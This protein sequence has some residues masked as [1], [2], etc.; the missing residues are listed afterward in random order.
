[1]NKLKKISLPLIA[2]EIITILVL[3]FGIKL[4]MFELVKS[5]FF[6]VVS[7]FFAGF[8][9]SKLLSCVNSS[10]TYAFSFGFGIG[11]NILSYYVGKT[12]KIDYLI[13]II[14]AVI[15]L[16]GA[17]LFYKDIKAKK[18]AQFNVSHGEIIFL[19]AILILSVIGLSYCNLNPT[20]LGYTFNYKDMIW[21]V[22]NINSLIL[23]NPPTD[24]RFDGLPFNYHYFASVFRAAMSIAT[25]ISAEK[26]MFFY[27]QFASV[28]F[29]FFALVAIGKRFLKSSTKALF[30]AFVF[31][32]TNSAMTE[33]IGRGVGYYNGLQGHILYLH[34]GL[35]FAV[36]FLIITILV[37]LKTINS[38][39]TNYAG[40]VILAGLSAIATGS[41]GPMGTI[42][43]AMA[44]GMVFIAIIKKHNIK[45]V[46]LAS[47]A[48]VI[49]FCLVFFTVLSSAT[50]DTYSIAFNP[51]VLYNISSIGW[52]TGFYV[53]KVISVVI[54]ILPL[55]LAIETGIINVFYFIA[56]TFIHFWGY[57]FFVSIPFLI[58]LFKNIF[59]FKKTNIDNFVLWGVAGSAVLAGYL[60]HSDGYGQVY[61]LMGATAIIELLGLIWICENF[62]KLKTVFKVLIAFTFCVSLWTGVSSHWAHLSNNSFNYVKAAF[63]DKHD[64]NA[65]SSGESITLAEYEALVWIRENTEKDA[66]FATDRHFD[67]T[68][69]ETSFLAD[70]T[71]NARYF[72]YSAYSARQMF[73]EGWSYLPRTEEMAKQTEARYLINVSFYD[74]KTENK[75]QLM[76]KNGVDYLIASRYINDN[77]AQLDSELEQV[78][79]NSDIAVYKP[80]VD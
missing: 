60:F 64:Q 33:F 74:E 7:V 73:L 26:V 34:N 54:G 53:K 13:L 37:Y 41:K 23:A 29:L 30:F 10:E 32:F 11:I 67:D 42:L 55:P 78:F 75:G 58:L 47:A 66:V 21:N 17:Y 48:V 38:F 72:Y 69:A 45:N 12:L 14:P 65:S 39:K 59:G 44:V 49:G 43:A 80:V 28:P 79:A 51:G 22:G 19:L 70:T 25:N 8:A 1:M 5:T 2:L 76:Q 18:T 52:L 57:L 68:K 71:N 61:Y 35:D 56:T 77:F 9:V 20:V 36:P 40:L 63:A 15:G 31:Y 24:I 46:I 16:Y 62:K 50:G 27:C 3:L 6:V 4:Q